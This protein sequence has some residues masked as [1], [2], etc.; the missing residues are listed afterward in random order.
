M[1]FQ[2]LHHHAKRDHWE[3]VH[4]IEDM[5]DPRQETEDERQADQRSVMERSDEEGVKDHLNDL[6]KSAGQSRGLENVFDVPPADKDRARRIWDLFE[7]LSGAGGGGF[8]D[9][10]GES[11]ATERLMDIVRKRKIIVYTY[12]MPARLVRGSRP[13]PAKL[14]RLYLA[15]NIR[16]TINLCREMHHGDVPIVESAGLT[17]RLKTEHIPIT[18]NEAPK[19]SQVLRLFEFLSDPDNV[20]AY[21]HCEQGIGRTGVMCACYRIGFNGWSAVEALNEAKRF[22][23]G[24]PTQEAFIL[25]FANELKDDPGVSRIFGELDF[26]SNEQPTTPVDTKTRSDCLDAA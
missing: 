16:S 5:Y 14:S 15:D 17:G 1:R 23:E 26:P 12:P 22:A 3:Y 18:D 10:A 7:N 25:R 24:M 4:A 21:I 8:E 2:I 20:P 11:S 13:T 6:A 9:L 19:Y